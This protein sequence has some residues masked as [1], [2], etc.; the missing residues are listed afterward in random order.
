MSNYPLLQ[1]FV[2]STPHRREY[3]GSQPTQPPTIAPHHTFPQKK[4]YYLSALEFCWLSRKIIIFFTKDFL[5]ELSMGCG[6]CCFVKAPSLSHHFSSHAQDSHTKPQAICYHRTIWINLLL[7][8]MNST[9]H[10][11]NIFFIKKRQ[12]WFGDI[13]AGIHLRVVQ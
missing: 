2:G 11:K 7:F 1:L 3:G 4:Y 5:V 12:T 8:S 10:K 9:S 6:G 13:A